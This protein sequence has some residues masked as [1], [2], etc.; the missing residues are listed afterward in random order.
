MAETASEEDT[1]AAEAPLRF[2]F[3]AAASVRGGLLVFKRKDPDEEYVEGQ[4][5]R[6][7]GHDS[8]KHFLRENQATKVRPQA[9]HWE[10]REQWAGRTRWGRDSS[11]YTVWRMK[12]WL[13]KHAL[14]DNPETLKTNPE[15]TMSSPASPK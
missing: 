13:S 4:A 11:F 12:R 3:P 15:T 6:S 5:K 7:D 9:G 8:R 2:H 1:G 10:G 14:L